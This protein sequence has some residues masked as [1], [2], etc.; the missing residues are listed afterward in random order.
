M[1]EAH[2]QSLNALVEQANEILDRLADA[3]TRL[4]LN[5]AP[6]GD[7][8]TVLHRV[9]SFQKQAES[10]LADL[11]ERESDNSKRLYDRS[12]GMVQGRIKAWERD[13][14]ERFNKMIVDTKQIVIEK[15]QG[16]RMV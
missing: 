7:D 11:Q 4:L 12:S 2:G 1:E 3:N 15:N 16:L 9:L 5:S 6:M 14:K 8:F 13:L 10:D